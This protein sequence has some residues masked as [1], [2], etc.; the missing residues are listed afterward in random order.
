M[1][2]C[3]HHWRRIPFSKCPDR[4]LIELFGHRRWHHLLYKMFECS[5]TPLL[6]SLSSISYSVCFCCLIGVYV[7]WLN[8]SFSFGW[9]RPCSTSWFWTVR[10]V[11][12]LTHNAKNMWWWKQPFNCF[13]WGR[14]KTRKLKMMKEYVHTHA[15]VCVHCDAA[16]A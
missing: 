16:T 3:S 7:P 1:N 8:V 9:Q 13:V 2:A 15:R 6:Y 11:Y 4:L 10:S 14:R 12:R 5:P